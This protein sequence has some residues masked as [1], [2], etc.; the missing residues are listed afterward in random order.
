MNDRNYE[1]FSV[2]KSKTGVVTVALNVP[3]RPLNVLTHEVM[4]ELDSIVSDLQTYADCRMIVF[5]SD[6]ESGFLAGADVGA[7]ARINCPKE[8]AKLIDAGQQL[9]HRIEWMPTPTV[10]VIHGPC[11]GGGLEWSLACDYRIAKDDAKTKIGLPEIKLG[12]IPGWGGTQRLPKFVPLS[13]AVRMILQGKHLSAHEALACGLVDRLVDS[14][15]F[16]SG[17]EQ[18]ISDVI[19][20]SARGKCSKTLR[21]RRWIEST[22]FGRHMILSATRKKIAS[23]AKLYPALNSAVKAIEASF[24]AASRW[25]S[26]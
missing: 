18:F 23:K 20:R 6:K 2:T 24:G 11:L 25:I 13:V 9:F 14:D 12:V 15:H 7:I 8:A 22:P 21:L 16:E 1:A 5:R 10:A 4:M 3:D 19:S 26:R 17:V